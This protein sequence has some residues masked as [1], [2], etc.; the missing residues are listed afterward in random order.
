MSS[1]RIAGPIYLETDLAR[2]IVEPLNAVTAALFLIVAAMWLVKLRSR[3]R[4][5]PFLLVC[6]ALLTVGGVGGTIY[7]AFRGNAVWLF[8]DWVPIAILGVAGS[9]YLFA[10]LLKQW[11][12]ALLVVPGY[13][14]FQFGNFNVFFQRSRHVAIA[15]SYTTLALL[16]LIPAVII[17]IKTRFRNGWCPLAAL[18]CFGVA[19]FCRQ[20][21]AN[22]PDLFPRGI[23]FLWHVFGAVA[24][25]LIFVYFD[26][27]PDVLAE[28]SD[29]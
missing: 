29:L 19:L 15:I 8:L 27:L 12:Y 23:H 26:R 28:R 20:Y 5:R 25:Y 13:V 10:K 1:N 6:V 3:W 14:A 21:D 9:V 4:Q 24:T 16:P 17:L 2:T 22:W 7:H 18:A 11:G